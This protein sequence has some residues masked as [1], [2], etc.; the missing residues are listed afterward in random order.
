MVHTISH[1][2][3]PNLIIHNELNATIIRQLIEY[4]LSDSDVQNNTHD[5]ERFSNEDTLN[6]WLKKGR[7]IFILT[8]ATEDLLGIIWF[9]KKDFP[10]YVLET[11][12]DPTIYKSMFSIRLYGKARGVGL[13]YPFASTVITAYIKSEQYQQLGS[14]GLWLCTF[15]HNIPAIKLYNKLGFQRVAIS[16]DDKEIGMIMEIPNLSPF[17]I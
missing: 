9:G 15:S 16:K 1:P 12:F 10:D 4:T 7:D 8:N 11:K 17:V 6:T 3:F 5:G 2:Q 14:K 13:A